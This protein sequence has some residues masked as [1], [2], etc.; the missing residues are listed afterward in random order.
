MKAYLT[1]WV[2][3][4][5]DFLPTIT[6]HE[7]ALFQQHGDWQADL[8]EQRLGFFTGPGTLWRLSLPNATPAIA[9][10]GEQL[11][12]WG[13]AQRWLRS[14]ADAELIRHSVAELGGHATRYAPGDD[15]FHPLPA[16]L[17]RYHRS[18]K[19]QLDPQGI[20]NPGRMYR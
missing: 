16:A 7:K 17:L 3:P 19:Q 18:L 2:P 4:R 1:K 12:D 20:F 15:A 9:L 8:R 10:P 13:G 5:D 11:I 6:E 14:D